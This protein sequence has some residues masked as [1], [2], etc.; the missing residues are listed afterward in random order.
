MNFLK[1]AIIA[2]LGIATSAEAQDYN[3]YATLGVN[4]NQIKHPI[5]SVGGQAKEKNLNNTSVIGRV[6]YNVNEFV[7]AEAEL[8][9]GVSET[10]VVANAK[11]KNKFNSGIYAVS[12]LPV[13]ESFAFLGRIG[14]YHSWSEEKLATRTVKFDGGGVAAGVG[15]QLML[16]EI[17]GIRADYTYYSKFN[18]PYSKT[19]EAKA[20]NNI[21]ISFVSVF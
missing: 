19:S 13:S 9:F 21:S 5:A 18:V 20:A 1:F 14:Y 15:A 6:G 3:F 17:S 11:Y 4:Q 2:A 16:D 8:G 12:F 10:D 7:S